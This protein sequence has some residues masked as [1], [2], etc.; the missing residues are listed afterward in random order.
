VYDGSSLPTFR[1]KLSAPSS[2]VKK[3]K[4]KFG[5]NLVSVLYR[6]ICFNKDGHYSTDAN[7]VYSCQFLLLFVTSNF[8]I[9]GLHNDRLESIKLWIATDSNVV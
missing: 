4:K 8:A 5:H 9:L 7:A 3:S 2:R 1:D 6:E